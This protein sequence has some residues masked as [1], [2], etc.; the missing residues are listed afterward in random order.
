VIYKKGIKIMGTR[1]LVIVKTK[2][3]IAIAQYG[4]YD[5]YPSSAGV[6]ILSF[7]EKNDMKVFAEKLKKCKFISEQQINKLEREVGEEA[8]KS[9]YE[10]MGVDIL[11]FVYDTKD[12]VSLRN[13]YKFAGDTAF[14]EWVYVLDMETSFLH[15]FKGLN[16][17]VKLEKGDM[18]YD[19]QTDFE[20]PYDSYCLGIHPPRL[21]KSVEFKDA[22][23]S[24]DM[25]N[26]LEKKLKDEES[27][28]PE[29][30][31]DD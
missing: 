18:F 7:I 3:R 21:V 27:L 20:T 11:K 9:I 8:L 12:V 25:M 10:V 16:R 24:Y 5:G 6:D 19:L 31:L 28:L 1:H 2:T 4:Q 30:S 22:G 26:A 13:D 17:H 29:Y 14:C 15:V 23:T